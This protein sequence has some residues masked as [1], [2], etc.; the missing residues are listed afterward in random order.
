MADRKKPGVALGASV[1]LVVLLVAYPLSFGPALW[2]QDR[3]W[4]P[5]WVTNMIEILYVPISELFRAHLVPNWYRS[6][7]DWWSPPPLLF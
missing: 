2:L 1:V 5:V 3:E 7:L 4:C 6:Y